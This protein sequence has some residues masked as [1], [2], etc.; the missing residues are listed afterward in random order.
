MTTLENAHRETVTAWHRWIQ[1]CF[2]CFIRRFIQRFI[3]RLT[4]H[5]ARYVALVLVLMV[6]GCASLH[7]QESGAEVTTRTVDLTRPPI[8]VW[9]RIRRGYAIPNLNTDLSQQWTE[10]YAKHPESLQRMADRSGRYLYYIVDEVNRRGLP[11]ELAL[12]PFVESAYNPNAYSRAKASGLWQFIPSTGNAFELEQTW[13]R[14]QRRDPIASTN[15][16]LDYLEYLYEKQGDWYLAFAS[17]NWGEGSVRRALGKNERAGKPLDYR[18]LRMPRETQNYVP[19]LQAIKNI[20]ADPERYGVLLPIIDNEPYFVTVKKD[21]D[22]DLKVAAELAEMPVEEFAAL[23]P[24]FNQGVILA[25]LNPA[26][27]LPRDKLPVYLANLAAYEG[28]LTSWQ[29]Y[30]AKKG[31]RIDTIAQTFNVSV[32]ALRRANN[33]KRSARTLPEEM[34]LIIPGPTNE[35]TV[36]T[37]GFSKQLS[38]KTYRVRSGDTLSGIARKFGTRVSTLRELN[39]MKGSKLRI[40]Q[41]LQVPG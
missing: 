14:D 34:V 33:L 15:A 36:A 31:E 30:P 18:Y 21:R 4:V 7:E 24:A 32:S 27:I 5:A 39:G 41:R 19:K 3:Q 17:Y 40:G 23:N 35:V 13:W 6:T 8:D 11:T 28:D 26:I 16:A 25:E 12:L 2:Q 9:E 38:T 1:D 22:I 29:K 10:Y 37:A 20:I